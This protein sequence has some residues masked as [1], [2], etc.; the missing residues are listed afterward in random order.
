M[1]I[2]TIIQGLAQFF[3]KT[4]EFTPV[5]A[6]L[7]SVGKFDLKPG[8]QVQAEILANLPN[9]RTIV[10][11]AGELLKMEL[12]LNVQPGETL[13]MTFVGEEPRLTFALSRSANSA[14]PVNISDTGKLL[15]MLTRNDSGQQAD[16][17]SRLKIIQ[18]GPPDDAS[19][20]AS[21]LRES[22][23]FSGVFYESHL[24]QWVLGEYAFKKLRR[25]P[26]GK[27]S[28]R[29][30]NACDAGSPRNRQPWTDDGSGSENLAFSERIS[31]KDGMDEFSSKVASETMPIVREQ[32][33]AMHS[34]MFLWQGEVWPDQYM[35][36]TV[37]EREPESEQGNGKQ[38][39]T[40]LRL[41]MNWL[42]TIKA[43][44][45][46]S[47]EGLRLDIITDSSSAAAAMVYEKDGLTESM[48]NAGL[49][50]MRMAID[51]E[52]NE[53]GN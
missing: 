41:K 2:N 40:T 6:E 13:A 34:G 22:L 36:W 19:M 33:Q 12:P 9:H 26:Q 30:K 17:L 43:T 45:K 46:L 21:L 18:D 7:Q 27:L 25:E 53:S 23:T 28:T 35:E 20:L 10:R 31:S 24:A 51:C 47:G 32:M 50:I 38:W 1:S 15:A 39:E 11:I 14:V 5:E 16:A 48:S 49:R 8:Q 3:A 29:T 44:L 42:G 4:P 52:K 37:G